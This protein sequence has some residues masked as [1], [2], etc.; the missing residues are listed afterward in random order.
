M[1]SIFAIG[2]GLTYYLG[3]MTKNQAHGWSVWSAMM[4]AVPGRRVALLVGGNGGQSDSPASWASPRQT[5]TWKA[6]KFALAFSIPPSSPPSRPTLPAARSIRC[7]IPSLRS[8]GFVPLFNIQLGEIIIGGVGAGLYG[9]LVFVV[10]AVFIAGLMVGPHAGIPRQKNPVLRREN[11]HA[12]AAGAGGVH[13]GICR[14]GFGQQMGTGRRLNN[15]GPHGLSEILYAL[16]FRQRQQRQ[17]FRRTERQYALAKHHHRPGHAD[18]A[19]PHDRAH[20]G[21]GRFAGQKEN[22]AAERRNFPGFRRHVSSCCC[23]APSC[24][25]AR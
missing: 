22:F 10:L 24:W 13:S 23:S 11:G 20:H 17:R 12:G 15:S 21:T 25:W 5:A 3:R 19:L 14:V 8:G 6:R 4:V 2:S 9:M 1:L 7:T 18:R 16:Q